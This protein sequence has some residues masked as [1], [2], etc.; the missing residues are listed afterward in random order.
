MFILK[1]CTICLFLVKLL[2][3]NCEKNDQIIFSWPYLT[4]KKDFP[5]SV[6]STIDINICLFRM[7]CLCRGD[8]YD[9]NSH[10]AL[11]CNM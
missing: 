2:V 7:K 4:D 8:I 9:E 1:E 3:F 10:V 5:S 6:V 11:M